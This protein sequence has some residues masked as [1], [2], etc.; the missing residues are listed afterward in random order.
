MIRTQAEGEDDPVADNATAD[1]RAMNRRAV[2]RFV[3]VRSTGR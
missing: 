2:V 3:G 1:G